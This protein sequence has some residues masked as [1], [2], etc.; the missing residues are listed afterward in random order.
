MKKALVIGSHASQSLSPLIFNYWFKKHNINAYYGF[1]E[2]KPHNFEKEILGVLNDE[3]LC[4]FNVTMPF[5][6][7]IKE[8]IHTLDR[9][10]KKIG[11]V[12]MVSKV[13]KRWIG[14]NTDWLGFYK[15]IEKAIE[16]KQK[17]SAF[18]IGCGGASKGIIYALKFF[19]FKKI[20]IYN[21]TAEKIKHLLND[22]YIYYVDYPD[23]AAQIDKSDIVINTTPIN[24]LEENNKDEN[25]KN[26]LVCDIVYK[27][28]ETPFLLSFKEEKRIYGISML[29][30][31]AVPCFEG[32][33]GVKPDVDKGLFDLL[34]GYLS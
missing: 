12:N 18:V 14:G 28:K 3:D 24:I 8:K 7:L 32:W 22:S 16:G 23:I 9:H 30:Y 26:T 33:F 10:S 25:Q 15:S 20:Y 13:N 4:G 21:R 19:G 17:N 29:V 11:A 31:Q 5:K 27:P 2:I 34:D 6:E 1:K